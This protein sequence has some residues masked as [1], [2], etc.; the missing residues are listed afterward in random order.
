MTAPI[1]VKSSKHASTIWRL[2]KT[3]IIFVAACVRLKEHAFPFDC[4]CVSSCL[5]DVCIHPNLRNCGRPEP[6]AREVG[7]LSYGAERFFVL[8]LHALW[9][10][11]KLSFNVRSTMRENINKRASSIVITV[12]KSPSYYFLDNHMSLLT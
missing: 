4:I 1:I 3:Y 7:L 11:G 5:Q 6:A 2:I 12:K 9:E 10:K 8:F